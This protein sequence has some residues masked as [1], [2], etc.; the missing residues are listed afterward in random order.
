[1]QK[2]LEAVDTTR[3]RLPSNVGYGLT[4]S[5]APQHRPHPRALRVADGCE[6]LSPSAFRS[7]TVTVHIVGDNVPIVGGHTVILPGA[8]GH[9]RFG[10]S[11]TV[12]LERAA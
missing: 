5:P 11:I 6:I 8:T 10:W 7:P 9:D 12:V 2:E 3:G 4:D 1:M